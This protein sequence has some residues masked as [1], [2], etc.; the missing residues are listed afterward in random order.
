MIFTNL[1]QTN[2]RT[3]VFGK[4]IE[5]YQRIG[6]TNEEAWE[7]INTGE[8]DHGTMVITDNQFSGKGR[9]NNDWYMS[10]SKS[11]AMSIIIKDEI[12]IEQ[13]LLVPLAAGLAVAKTLK[14]R[15]FKPQL[16]WPN[17]ILLNSKKCGGILCES[18]VQKNKITEMVIGIGLNVNDQKSDLNQGIQN[19]ATSLLIES[20][21]P[22]QRELI[23]AIITSYFEQVFD[24]LSSVTNQWLDY[25]YH[26][27]KKIKFKYMNDSE[28]GV[29]KGISDKG[30]AKVE[31]ENQIKEFPSITIDYT[32]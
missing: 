23:S 29:F 18:R 14:N 15:S 21:Y 8:A 10:P 28:S 5:Y 9:D 7:L 25:C 12:T 30:F 32:T 27:N 4:K 2:L 26:L 24:N 31:I 16:K 20:G 1:I 22:N 13:A 3:K 6:S 11:L 19:I 17:D